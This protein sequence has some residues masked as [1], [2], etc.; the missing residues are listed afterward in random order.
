MKSEILY[1]GLKLS[2]AEIF[3]DQNKIDAIKRLQPPTDEKKMRSF[4]G[5]IPYCSKFLPVLSLSFIHFKTYF[6]ITT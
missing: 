6:K 4:L 1:M 2:A 5:M 3:P